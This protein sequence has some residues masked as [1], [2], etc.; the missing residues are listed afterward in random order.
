MNERADIVTFQGSPLNLLGRELSV[1]EQTP[2][3]VLLADDLTEVKLS[4]FRGR[5]CVI[6]AVPSLDTPVCDTEVRRFNTEAAALGDDVAILAVSM[7][8]PFAQKRWCGGA[9]VEA[10]KTLSD[11]RDA[12]FGEAFGVLI[13]ELRLLGR[14]VFVM[15][16]QGVIQ[17]IQIVKEITDEPDYE[18]ALN[19]IRNLL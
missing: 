18:A 12:A 13:K 11:H 5:V 19:A 8:L 3:A 6:L 1:G 7:D 2:E 15:D 10:V 14:A 4:E 9:G 17:Y 16:R